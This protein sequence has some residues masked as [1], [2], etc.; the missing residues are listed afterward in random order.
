MIQRDNTAENMLL[1][2]KLLN[3]ERPTFLW[4]Q[5]CLF[6]SCGR[7]CQIRKI[8]ITYLFS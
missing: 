3:F 7:S 1:P 4:N 5:R 8:R 6:E 2:Q